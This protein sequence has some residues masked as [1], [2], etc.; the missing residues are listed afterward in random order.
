ME[1]PQAGLFL[2]FEWPLYQGGLKQN[3]VR[4]AESRRAAAEDALDASSTAA[5]REVALAFDQVGTGLSQYDAAVA[6]QAAAQTS[7]DSA[8]DAFAHGVGTF[9]DAVSAATALAAARATVA[10]VH[11]QALINGGRPGL[12]RRRVDVEH[13]AGDFGFGAD[14]A[15]M[16][17]FG[18]LLAVAILLLGWLADA[19]GRTPGDAAESLRALGLLLTVVTGLSS[20]MWW[21]QSASVSD[22]AAEG[23]P[24][25]R[26]HQKDANVLNGAAATTTGVALIGSVFSNVA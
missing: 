26:R 9:A 8:S 15:L 25:A 2:R 3:Q 24:Q 7:Y 22:L 1:Q 5:L 21:H 12:R 17:L 18:P 23:G 19:R 11:A 6:L 14:A 13:R 4:L 10:K 16:K 20:A